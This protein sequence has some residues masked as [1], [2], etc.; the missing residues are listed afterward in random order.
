MGQTTTIIPSETQSRAD[1][2]QRMTDSIVAPIEAGV[3]KWRMPWALSTCWA[4]VAM[5]RDKGG[6]L[7]AT[8][9]WRRR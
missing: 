2:Y 7:A 1:I 6:G 4:D 8:T 5:A 9:D 3:G